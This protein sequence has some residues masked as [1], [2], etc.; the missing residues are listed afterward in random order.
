M[1]PMFWSPRQAEDAFGIEDRLGE[2]TAPTLVIA[3]SAGTSSASSPRLTPDER[4]L[5]LVR[6]PGLVWKIADLSPGFRR[7]E[8]FGLLPGQV[9]RPP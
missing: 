4:H 1:L 7:P 3:D 5:A 6:G 9:W 8:A 2:I